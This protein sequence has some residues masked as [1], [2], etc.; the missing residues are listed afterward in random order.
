MK[1]LYQG[2]VAD[3]QVKFQTTGTRFFTVGSH[4]NQEVRVTQ[5]E[6]CGQS[7][8]GMEFDIALLMLV[9]TIIVSTLILS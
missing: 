9:F 4:S 2:P 8:H 1:I 7:T 5:F 6:Y 3:F